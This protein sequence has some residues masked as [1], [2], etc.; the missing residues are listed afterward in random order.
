MYDDV[1]AEN[2]ENGASGLRTLGI[3]GSK[4]L[5]KLKLP[6]F[7]FVDD[8]AA[9]IC[10]YL[11]K[12]AAETRASKLK[13]KHQQRAKRGKS[14]TNNVKKSSFKTTLSGSITKN[15]PDYFR[16]VNEECKRCVDLLHANGIFVRS[17]SVRRVLVPPADNSSEKCMAHISSS[18]SIDPYYHPANVAFRRAQKRT[19][20][21]LEGPSAMADKGGYP[22]I[23]TVYDEEESNDRPFLPRVASFDATYD[24]AFEGQRRRRR[25]ETASPTP[26]WP[27][28]LLDKLTLCMDNCHIKKDGKSVLFNLVTGK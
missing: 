22:R 3:P 20:R 28:H 13:Q 8:D 2:D 16:Q 6:E 19:L 1:V 18:K 24:I 15:K 27:Q 21:K 4:T 11:K 23:D 7:G 17:S 5:D 14:E 10:I 12:I 9:S 25:I 26:F